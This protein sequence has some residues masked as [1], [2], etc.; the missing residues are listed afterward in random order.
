MP[1]DLPDGFQ[2]AEYLLEHGMV[3]RIVRRGHLRDE[4]GTV[5]R[6]LMGMS[7][8]ERDDEVPR[9]LNRASDAD[10]AVTEGTSVKVS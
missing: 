2:T 8:L 6:Q 4:L 10:P 5:L 9:P 3:D 7:A 1:K